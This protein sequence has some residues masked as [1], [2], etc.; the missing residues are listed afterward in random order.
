MSLCIQSS[1]KV[2][3][4]VKIKD[5]KLSK[6]NK[7]KVAML[8]GNTYKWGIRLPTGINIAL[9]TR[10]ITHTRL[11]QMVE[12]ITS[13]SGTTVSAAIP[14]PKTRPPKL[15]KEQM[16]K[17][18]M[19]DMIKTKKLFKLSPTTDPMYMSI[20][21]A[22]RLLRAIEVG[23]PAASQ[24]ITL[25]T[26][27]VNEKGTKPLA[28]ELSLP[29]PL[30]IPQI[31]AFSGDDA[32]L[33]SLKDLCYMTGGTELIDKISE[34]E[35]IGQVDKVVATPDVAG[36]LQQK[37]GKIWGRKGLIP[38]VKKATVSKDLK[39]LIQNS[40]GKLP[41]KQRGAG[42]Y[43]Y[44]CLNVGR[45]TMTDEQILQN[46]ISA[47]KSVLEAL[48]IQRAHADRKQQVSVLGWSTLSTAR[49]SSIIVD[50]M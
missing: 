41:F 37:L 21:S 18:K 4:I 3:E 27:M 44:L 11:R 32:E 20:P 34:G 19:K 1:I 39:Q 7:Q 47:R 8:I 33:E 38:S 50:F 23:Q 22:L 9:Q 2:F 30:K 10:M 17:K 5:C 49:S 43:T 6:L 45:C 31:V 35:D 25:T 13:N 26:R 12:P 40:V 16:K 46:I 28:G 14:R 42:T 24:T 36:Y 48:Q 15:T 29:T